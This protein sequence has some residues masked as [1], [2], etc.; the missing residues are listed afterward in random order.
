VLA[1]LTEA[2]VTAKV[3]GAEAAAFVTGLLGV[4]LEQAASDRAQIPAKTNLAGANQG[5]VRIRI[6]HM[7]GM[8][9]GYTMRCRSAQASDY[10]TDE[11]ARKMLRLFKTT[12]TATGTL[13]GW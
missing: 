12:S 2:D 1:E 13:P 7:F 10:L 8:D 9:S 6:S 4:S 3:C 11:A 5:A